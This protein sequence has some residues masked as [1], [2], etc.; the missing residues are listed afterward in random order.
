MAVRCRAET[1]TIPG[2]GQLPLESSRPRPPGSAGAFLE[3]H[4][5]ARLESG[6]EHS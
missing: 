1:A 6:Q 5:I 4:P 3:P 2:T